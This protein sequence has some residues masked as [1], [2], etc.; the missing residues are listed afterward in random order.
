MDNCA[1]LHSGQLYSTIDEELL[2]EQ[3]KC[4][5]LLYDYNQTRPSQA[6]EREALLK[7]MLAQVGENCYIEPPFHTNWGG[8]HLH[9]GRNVYAN[10][11][12]TVVDDTHVYIGD[13]T[14]IG[15]NVVITTA[16]HPILPQLRENGA[17][18]YNLPVRIGR[19]CWIG[20]GACILPGVSIGD[21][22]VIG[23]GSVVT[24]DIPANVVAFGSPCRVIRP[25]GEQ[26]KESYFRDRKI[27]WEALG[28]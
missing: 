14:M 6:K 3:A 28:R 17:Y 24:R 25:I 19:N 26:D 18:Q 13:F 23:A 1:K 22:T 5:E 10:F 16:G 8:R 21:N 20:A 15:P 4:L 27:D 7:K 12:F 9:L 11:N 2:R